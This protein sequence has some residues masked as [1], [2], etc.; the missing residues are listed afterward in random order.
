VS[1]LDPLAVL[2][3][4]LVANAQVA[5]DEAILSIGVDVAALQSQVSVG[6]VVPATVLPPQN[7]MDLVSFLGQT[8]PA[9]LPPG[10][11]PGD[12]IA[13]QVTGFTPDT[14]QVQNLGLLDTSQ[15]AEPPSATPAPAPSSSAP[16]SASTASPVPLSGASLSAPPAQPSAPL[17][18]SQQQIVT[19]S[20][21]QIT[22]PPARVPIVPQSNVAPPRSV[23]VRAAMPETAQIIDDDLAQQ[24]V[25]EPIERS[26]VE[27]RID[28]MRAA[29]Q[30]APAWAQRGVQQPVQ[31]V[32]PPVP[33]SQSQ[34][35]PPP[36]SKFVA[37]PIIRDVSVPEEE[38]AAPPQAS[39]Q[40]TQAQA[41][42]LPQS[43]ESTLLSQLRVPLTPVT[44]AAV[45]MMGNAAQN[46]TSAYER[47]E[48]AL[49][50]LA[51]EAGGTLR[52]MLGF[53][54]RFDLRNTGA[55]PEQIAT[56][57]SDVLDGAEAK[58]AQAVRAWASLV[59]L[60]EPEDEPAPSSPAPAFTSLRTEAAFSQPAAPPAQANTTAA[61]A[62]AAER[63]AAMDYD[64]KSAI[65]AMMAQPDAHGDS[66]L[67]A[68]ALRDAL[69]AT[70]AVQLNVL[71]AQTGSPNV[72]AIPLPAY[73]RDGG[74]PSQLRISRD[75]G[76]GK[77][78]KLDADN[79]HI[80]FIL[81]TASLGTVAI[82]VQTVGR[83]VSVDVKTEAQSAARRFSDT[84]GD[85]RS[86]LEGLHYKVAS[87]AAGVAPV[88]K[89]KSETKAEPER[90]ERKSFW[91]L[92]A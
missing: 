28:L 45:R 73:Y 10:V 78:A 85:L 64:V 33:S 50:K 39:A 42:R 5:M 12:T 3:N 35:A 59:P 20:S 55:L 47:L 62:V 79:F 56:Y 71:N 21:T 37:P 86:R 91:D 29:P 66:P 69:T 80:S 34:A 61:A 89:Q 26:A 17:N 46:L 68:G 48:S 90:N 24:I 2:A 75:V 22:P 54:S 60:A 70:T 43:P 6:D 87:I 58:I 52:S 16:S 23:F 18:L 57:V 65:L 84:L 81:D 88:G 14:V 30:N 32:Q 7:G 49:A 38:E 40:M 15:A 41:A 8:L 92:R 4:Q 1:G 19:T 44:L 82:D 31:R 63:V 72:I 77:N 9:Q 67:I 25:S 74:E 76:D 53:V 83:A 36:A 11:Y 27:T 13:L 51:P